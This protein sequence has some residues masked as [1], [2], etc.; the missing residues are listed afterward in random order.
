MSMQLSSRLY[1]ISVLEN[2]E[3]SRICFGII[4]IL[5]HYTRVVRSVYTRFLDPRTGD[6]E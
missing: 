4:I 5:S 1:S 3:N 2:T 6:L